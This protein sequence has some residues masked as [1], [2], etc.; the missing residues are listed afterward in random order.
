MDVFL[1]L[2][3]AILYFW[4]R[5]FGSQYMTWRKSCCHIVSYFNDFVTFINI[6]CKRLS[7]LNLK[8]EN[9]EQFSKFFWAV[10]NW[11]LL[12]IVMGRWLLEKNVPCYDS[13][14]WPRQTRSLAPP[15]REVKK[16]NFEILFLLSCV[17]GKIDA[18]TETHT[19][20]AP[21]IGPLTI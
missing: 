18:S 20:W 8:T 13:S 4:T 14:L 1:G 6:S 15:C 11:K 19:G 21:K 10:C 9:I 5:S 12:E 16:Y 17:S 3:A 7:C 2:V